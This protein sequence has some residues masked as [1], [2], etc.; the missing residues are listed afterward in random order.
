MT[1]RPWTTDYVL[2]DRARR[3][4]YDAQRLSQPNTWADFE[5]YFGPSGDAQREQ[6]SSA[7]FFRTHAKSSTRPAAAGSSAG[8]TSDDTS[9]ERTGQPSATGV[10]GDVFAEMLRP[11]VSRLAPWW[12]WAG[13]A[14][15]AALGFI[16]GNVP[17]AMAGAVAGNRL[18]A[19]RDAKG[20]SVAEVF[21]HLGAGQRAE[22]IRHLVL[23]LLG[24]QPETY[25]ST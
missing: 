25:H 8:S 5:Q 22:I 4:E 20:K 6:A 14:S 19:V 24:P 18:G 7:N 10:F 2:S 17:G 13:S 1:T 9:S 21:Y 23:K 16:V 11:E 15:G 12:T 3:S